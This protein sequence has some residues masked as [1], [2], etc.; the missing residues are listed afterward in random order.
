[1]TQVHYRIGYMREI[2]KPGKTLS[3]SCFG[4]SVNFCRCMDS[5]STQHINSHLILFK[6]G[7]K[8][9]L[10]VHNRSFIPNHMVK[11]AMTLFI[12]RG[13]VTKFSISHWSLCACPRVMVNNKS[14]SIVHVRTLYATVFCH[15]HYNQLCCQIC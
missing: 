4:L 15:V 2:D 13:S 10:V 14:S 8:K 12:R 3:V 11:V 1:M 9:S 7:I 6:I 5:H